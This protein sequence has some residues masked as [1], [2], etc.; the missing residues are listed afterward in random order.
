M[1]AEHAHCDHPKVGDIRSSPLSVGDVMVTRPK[2][3]PANAT[4]GEL[5]EVFANPHVISALLVDGDLFAGIVHRDALAAA[6]AADDAPATDLA[7]AG[8]VTV[9]PSMPLPDAVAILDGADSRRLV[10]LADDGETL[11]GLL[12]LDESR[13]SF[14]Q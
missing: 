8:T 3:T 11:A 10:V 9:R 13:S 5:R 7:A 2:T 1:S 6:D 14:C 12:C 4:V